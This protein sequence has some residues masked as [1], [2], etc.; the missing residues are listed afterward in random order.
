MLPADPQASIIVFIDNAKTE[1]MKDIKCWI[2]LPTYQIE[3]ETALRD[4]VGDYIYFDCAPTENPLVL[5][6]DGEK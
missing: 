4:R 5:S 6:H 3:V 1:K 2:F